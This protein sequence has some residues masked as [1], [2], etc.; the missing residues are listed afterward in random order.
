MTRPKRIRERQMLVN[1]M[2]NR[3]EKVATD[4]P[5]AVIDASKKEATIYV[6]GEIWRYG[7]NAKDFVKEINDLDVGTIHLRIDSPGGDVFAARAMQTAIRQH[8]ANVIAHIDGLA[9]SAATFLAMGADEIEIVE[10][11]FFMIHKAASFLDVFGYF[12]EDGMANL[13]SEI[14]KEIDLLKKVD[15]SIISDYTKKTGKGADEIKTWMADTKWFSAQE[16]LAAGFVDRIYEG[17]PV[18]NRF[19][20]SFFSNAPKELIERPQPRE[21]PKTTN[22]AALLRR[23]EL[24][25]AQ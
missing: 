2:R 22:T 24:E 1:L 8:K 25:I 19:D 20:L 11:G 7:I 13:I 21:E 12:S 9:A 3:P 23:L 17:K 18:E 15:E 5:K 10:G 16:A 14:G 6:Y 4:N